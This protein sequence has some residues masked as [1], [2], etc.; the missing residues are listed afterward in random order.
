MRQLNGRDVDPALVFRADGA[1]PVFTLRVKRAFSGNKEA[2]FLVYFES[3]NN[4]GQQERHGPD[5]EAALRPPGGRG[6][7]FRLTFAKA[8]QRHLH[9]TRLLALRSVLRLDPLLGG[10]DGLGGSPVIDAPEFRHEP[11]APVDE[12]LVGH[13]HPAH[14]VSGNASHL[15]HRPVREVPFPA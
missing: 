14:P 9:R 12:L 1:I 5:G 2:S 7:G 3:P 11:Y 8:L 10:K 6:L 15:R 13:R 4:K